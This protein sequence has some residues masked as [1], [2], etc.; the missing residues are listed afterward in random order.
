MKLATIDFETYYDQD[1]SLSKMTTEAYIRDARFEIIGMGLKWDDEPACWYP[2]H[3]LQDIFWLAFRKM[4]WSNIAIL[5]HNTFFDGAILSWKFGIK[6]RLWLDTLAMARPYHRSN[7]GGSLKALADHYQLGTKGT[8]VV[9]AK[10][11]HLSEF[12]PEGL[13]A[14]GRYCC[15]DVE[16]TSALFKQLKTLIPPTEIRV[17]D[18]N[19]RM[20][21]EPRL[22]LD[23][24]GLQLHIENEKTRQELLVQSCELHVNQLRSSEQ[25]AEY[26]AALGVVAP[27][28]I[29]PTTKKLT[30][31]FAKTDPQFLELLEHEDE[32]VRTAVAARIGVRSSIELTR[33][34]SLLGV[35]GRGLLPIMLNYYGAH[36]GRDSGGDN[37]NLQNLPRNGSIR[38]CI[39]APAGY[40]I[41]SADLSQIEARITAWLAGQNDLIKDFA[42]KSDPERDVYTK[43]ASAIYQRDITKK[44]KVERFVG[45]T[46]ILGLGYGMSHVKLRRTLALGVGGLKVELT[47]GQASEIV[48]IYRYKYKRINNLWAMFSRALV[49]MYQKRSVLIN[50]GGL[51]IRVDENGIHLPNDMRIIYDNLVFVNEYAAYSNS[52]RQTAAYAKALLLDVNPYLAATTSLTQIHGSKAVENTVQALANIILKN[53]SLKIGERYP[54]VFRV[55]D[56][57]VCLIPQGEELCATEYVNEAMTTPLPWATTLPLECE[58]GIADNY[59]DV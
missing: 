17:I 32:R 51:A 45:K 3:D 40:R 52:P 38:R 31:A 55:H 9:L 34:E 44:D 24:R 11:V 33:A 19:V 18:Q 41:L 29:S 53:A 58:V 36:T 59:G 26:L 48:Q 22:E 10:G 35:S 43:Y 14:Y 46:C 4:D 50:E 42:D 25:F 13:D 57:V 12:T 56:E 28:K 16:L 47:E 6:P 21:T 49:A 8:E 1:Y 5:C 20:Y 30:Y 54:V 15:T 2:A 37:L 39:L 23:P 7:V 27:K